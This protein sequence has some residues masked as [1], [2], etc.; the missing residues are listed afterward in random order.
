LASLKKVYRNSNKSWSLSN[1]LKVFTNIVVSIFPLYSFVKR[2]NITTI[3]A[4]GNFA[5]LFALPLVVLFKKK[6]IVIQHLLYEQNSFEGRLLKILV[7]YADKFICVSQSVAGNILSIVGKGS[8]NKLIVIYNGLSLENR[9]EEKL[10]TRVSPK[11]IRFAIVGSIIPQKGHDLILDAFS[12]LASNFPECRLFVFGEPREEKSSKSFY[13]ALKEKTENLLIADEIIFKGYVEKKTDLYNQFDIL[14]NYS[15]V[16]E[17]FSM[18][19][20]EALAHN[21][22]VIASNEGGPAEIIEHNVNGFIVEP[23]N[24]QALFQMMQ[25][26]VSVFENNSMNDIRRNGSTTVKEK[27][28]LQQFVESYKNIFKNYSEEGY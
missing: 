4:N 19:V 25:Q 24:K 6:L 9:T 7:K 17:S 18:V 15:V 2:K 22:I 28:S 10:V 11:E 16:P 12:E 8:Q 27:F 21:K 1:K 14:I 13:N 3:A 5:A 23:R 20:L 26:V